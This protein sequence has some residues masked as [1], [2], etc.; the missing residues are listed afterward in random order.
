MYIL[1]VRDSDPICMYNYLSSYED[2]NL[3]SC[4]KN[5]YT[6]DSTME[7]ATIWNFDIDRTS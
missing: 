7:F 5:T 1:Y 2:C 4:L 6:K 3:N